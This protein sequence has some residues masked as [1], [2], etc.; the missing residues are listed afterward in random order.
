[1]LGGQQLLSKK[2]EI[3]LVHER[4]RN[5]VVNEAVCVMS[6]KICFFN[7]H[8]ADCVVEIDFTRVMD[9]AATLASL[10][11]KHASI[12]ILQNGLWRVAALTGQAAVMRK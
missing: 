8:K 4:E 6:S 7:K 3:V 2:A 9:F 12:L 1:M 10:S 5:G 11:I